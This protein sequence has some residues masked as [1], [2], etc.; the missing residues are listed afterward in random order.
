MSRVQA[1]SLVHLQLTA[2]SYTFRGFKSLKQQIK[3]LFL[4]LNKPQAAL[5]K[6]VEL[7]TYTKS[8]VTRNYSEKSINGILDYV[9]EGGKKNRKR[10]ASEVDVEV[11]RQFYEVTKASME[12]A[13]N[14]VRFCPSRCNTR[15]LKLFGIFIALVA[16]DQHEA[17]ETLVGSKGVQPINDCV[18]FFRLFSFILRFALTSC[19]H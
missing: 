3:L 2:L 14:D 10:A 8:A 9:G 16:E 18:S 4:V 1:V 7:L 6:Y 5:E 11:L 19:A 17:R 15:S 13:K 12:D